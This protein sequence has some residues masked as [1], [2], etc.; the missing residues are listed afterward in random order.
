MSLPSYGQLDKWADREDVVFFKT[1]FKT[2][3]DGL[4]PVVYNFYTCDSGCGVS[5]LETS[6]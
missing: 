3:G 5:V 2:G 4:Y 1:K 6:V